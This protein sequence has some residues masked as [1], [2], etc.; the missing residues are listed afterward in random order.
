MQALA[1]AEAQVVA[2]RDD[3]AARLALLAPDLPRAHGHAPRHLPLPRAALSFM[4]WQPAAVCSIRPTHRPGQPVVAGD[5]RAPAAGWRRGGRAG[6]PSSPAVGPWLE[7]IAASIGVGYL[8][9][10]GSPTPSVPRSGSS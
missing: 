8:E 10:Q 1:W 4:R 6:A 3:P 9:H 7:F 2:A 5:Q